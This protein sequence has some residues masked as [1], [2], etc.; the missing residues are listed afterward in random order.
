MLRLK[1]TQAFTLVELAIV[2][3]IIMILAAIAIPKYLNYQ[4]M[5]KQTEARKGLGTLAKFQELYY[6][7]N[8]AYTLDKNA[9]GFAMRGN[10]RYYTYEILE[11]DVDGFK[12]KATARFFGKKDEWTIDQ[13]L[14]LVHTEQG[15]R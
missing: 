9:I 12:A 8:D 3:A 2:V 14:N 15:C 1:G 11:A 10:T 5:S 13:T 7:E 6:G 4:C